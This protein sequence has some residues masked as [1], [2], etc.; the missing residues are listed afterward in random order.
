[1]FLVLNTRQIYDISSI[2]RNVSGR[3]F[4]KVSGEY[5]R[6]CPHS[7]GA[8]TRIPAI[9]QIPVGKATKNQTLGLVLKL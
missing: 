9:W 3:S 5:A 1:M 4:K 7:Q 8:L 6:I 2:N